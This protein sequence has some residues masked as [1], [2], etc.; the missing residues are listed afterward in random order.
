MTNT[1]E[2]RPEP[3]SA[4]DARP[5]AADSRVPDEADGAGPARADASPS[6]AAGRTAARD[7]PP[8]AVGLASA[9]V[10]GGGQA[11]NRQWG[12][13]LLFLAIMAGTVV[14]ELVTGHYQNV[15]DY[16]FRRHGGFFLRG[17][18]GL[19]TLGTQPRETGLT[20]L[21][22]GDHSIVLMVNGLIAALVLLLLGLVAAGGILDAV[23]TRR[24]IRR[25]GSAPSSRAWAVDLWQSSYAYIMLSP[26][27]V[28]LLFVSALPILFGILIAFTNYNR[29]N[30]PPLHLV[31]WVGFSNFAS[32]FSI[33]AWST[34]FLGVLT[35][36]I[37]WALVA[38]V[39]TYLFGFF[40]AV[41]L[42]SS[43]VRFPRFWRSIYILPWAVPAMIS[44]L[45]FRSMFNGQFGPISQFLLDV[46]LTDER[47]YWFTDPG[48]AMLA[49]ILAIL[50]NLWLGFPYFMALIGGALTT[51]DR[52]CY[53]AAVLDGAS[54]WQILRRI[55][56][57]IVYRATAPLAVLA[58]VSNFNNF[59]VIY[60][61]T[62]GGPANPDYQFAG[63]TDL[64]ITWLFTLTVD[65]RL[66]NIGAVM[67]IVIFVM[68]GTFSLWNLKRSRAFDEL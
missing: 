62:Q 38:T 2:E 18:W 50:V 45:V 61:L 37:V 36:T 3:P 28:L 43:R 19:I 25:T 14:T 27:L 24:T 39:T 42:N 40:Q 35:W 8:W 44:A 65:N 53:E 32:I 30:L 59:G 5:A 31:E 54:S 41:I 55:T 23:R 64:L 34:T 22:E 1:L 33:S 58:F 15:V 16:S 47:I 67:S 9:V 26:L 48:N 49:R 11:L 46:G 56:F 20:G 13:S 52:N 57:P 68:V 60:F 17:L 6:A 7:L 4:D 29:D 66:Y 51:V 21:T 12:K 63:S 10:W